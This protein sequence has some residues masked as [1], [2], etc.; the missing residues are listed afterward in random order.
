MLGN[1]PPGMLIRNMPVW[2]AEGPVR[3]GHFAH[4]LQAHISTH[5]SSLTVCPSSDS[6]EFSDSEEEELYEPI[7]PP[8]TELH[9]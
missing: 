1:P 7:T 2:I 5:A 3:C 8:P 9:D 6:D 4:E